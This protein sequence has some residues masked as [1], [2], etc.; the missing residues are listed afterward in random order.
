VIG[1]ARDGGSGAA[2]GAAVGAGIGAAVGAVG[3]FFESKSATERQ[4]IEELGG[5][6]L[7]EKI[8]RPGVPVSGFVFFPRATYTGVRV[9]AVERASG[10]AEEVYGQM[11]KLASD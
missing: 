7:G 3:G 1:A 10:V 5:L 6:Y 8:A 11:V 2:T 9:I 4:I